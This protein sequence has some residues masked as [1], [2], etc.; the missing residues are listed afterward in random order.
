MTPLTDYYNNPGALKP[1]NG[2]PNF[3]EGQFG[4]D[5]QGFAIFKERKYGEQALI[6]D[7]NAKLKRGLTTPQAFIAE[8][9]KGDKPENQASYAVFLAGGLNLKSTDD[10]FPKDS[11][12]KI[13]KLIT[14]F[15]SGRR[16]Q[17]DAGE[18]PAPKAPSALEKVQEDAAKLAGNVAEEYPDALRVALD[19]AGA[20]AGQQIGT[21]SEAA[22]RRFD[23]ESR[24]RARTAPPQAQPAAQT[25][26]PDT[27]RKVPGSSGAANWTRVMG[28]EIPDVLA[29]SAESMRKADPRG[30]QAIIDR[31]IEAMKKIRDLGH[32][33]F[34]LSGTGQSQLMLPEQAAQYRAAQAQ[35]PKPSPFSQA[36]RSVARGGSG[37]MQGLGTAYRAVPGVMGALS[38]LGAAELGQEAYKRRDDP[39]GASIAGAG[40]L[41]AAASLVPTPVTRIGG[42]ALATASPLALYLYDKMRKQAPQSQSIYEGQL[43]P[44]AYMQQ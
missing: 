14:Q 22:R 41:G 44:L 36:L 19:V 39:I 4:V 28:K 9:T 7:I 33:D 1:P 40:A 32:G 2:K 20:S 43:A 11:V 31:D 8:Y 34:R 10:P 27:T 37:M 21:Q 3:Y 15:E 30:G 25:A 42:P 17:S 38:G 35:P 12:P 24:R 23:V 18:P 16:D 5:E 6:G 13:A 29:E 26:V